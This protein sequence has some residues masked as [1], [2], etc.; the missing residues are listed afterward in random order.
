MVV[1]PLPMSSIRTSYWRDFAPRCA[2]LSLKIFRTQRWAGFCSWKNFFQPWMFHGR[3]PCQA[4]NGWIVCRF[5][6]ARGGAPEQERGVLWRCV[7]S[8]ALDCEDLQ[9]ANSAQSGRNRLAVSCLPA[10]GTGA[11]PASRY[12]L[13]VDLRDHVTIAGKQRLSRAHLGT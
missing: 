2:F 5:H 1:V 11:I 8:L 12:A 9:H 10:P 4:L 3:C 6:G 13:L 7:S